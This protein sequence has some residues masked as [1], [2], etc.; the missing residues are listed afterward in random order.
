MPST[1]GA[2]TVPLVLERARSTRRDPRVD[3]LQ[4]RAV[5]PRLSF[6]AAQPQ[7]HADFTRF[8]ADLG[9]PD[10]VPG[11]ERWSATMLCDTRFLVE[12]GRKVGYAWLQTFG[13]RGY[14]RH[15]VIDASA[16][17]RGL[18]AVLMRHAA[19]D[20]RERGCTRWELNVKR[21]NVPAL[22]LYERCGMRAQYDAHFLEMPWRCAS[23]LATYAE[24]E[25]SSPARVV[26]EVD[27]SNDAAIGAHYGLPDGFLRFVRNQGRRVQ[28]V[29]LEDELPIGLASFDPS[30][31]GSFPFRVRDAA[32]ARALLEDLR[33]HALPEHD[34]LRL[35]V[36]DSS[37]AARA[38][39]AAGAKLVFEVVHFDGALDDA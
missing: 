28:R 1:N 24:S 35:F 33:P 6:V 26:R 17:G 32:A 36:E 21:E 29:V 7:D 9:V 16:R 12:D 10:P 14:V 23:A 38:L 27:D 8:F 37:L 39:I 5:S 11:P 25:L 13:A 3:P 30:F 19:S 18:G 15:V 4:V 22:R 34:F 31:P 2:S 20:L